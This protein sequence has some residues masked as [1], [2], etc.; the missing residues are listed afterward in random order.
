MPGTLA[1]KGLNSHLAQDPLCNWHGL[2]QLPAHG[3]EQSET[4]VSHVVPSWTV[5]NCPAAAAPDILLKYHLGHQ[6][7]PECLVGAL[8]TW[9]HFQTNFL[10]M[11]T[12]GAKSWCL[13]L[14]DS[15]RKPGTSSKL[16]LWA[17]SSLGGC[18]HFR[19]VSVDG[20]SHCVHLHPS[21]CLPFNKMKMN[22]KKL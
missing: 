4:M 18:G 1:G 19:R 3:F 7:L 2:S 9:L 6:P 11:H 10:Q 13:G 15:S 12:L 5:R 16:L 22:K 21:P 14:C 17:W 8:G 20:R